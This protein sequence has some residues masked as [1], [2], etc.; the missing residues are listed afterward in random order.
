MHPEHL[1]HL[2]AN[3]AAQT[4]R[5]AWE[6]VLRILLVELGPL[7]GETVLDRLLHLLVNE[8]DHPH[9]P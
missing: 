6:N 9:F 2:A 1:E 7:L 8:R 5:A 4:S 3:A